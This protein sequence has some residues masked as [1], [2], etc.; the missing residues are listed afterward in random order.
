MNWKTNPFLL[1]LILFSVGL[2]AQVNIPARHFGISFGNSQRFTGIRLNPVDKNIIRIN[3]INV[4]VWPPNEGLDMTGE[5]NGLAIGLPVAAGSARQ[6]GISIG[7]GAVGAAETIRGINLGGLGVGA[8]VDV[9]GLNIGGLGVGAGG[10]VGGINIGGL[11]LGAGERVTGVNIGGLGLGAGESVKGVSIGGL[12]IGAGNQVIGVNIAGL[13]IGAGT[14]LIGLNLAGLGMGSGVVMRGINIAGLGIGAP[15]IKGITVAL[16]VRSE[17]I[18]GLTVAPVY[19]RVKPFDPGL[20]GEMRG[21]AVSAFN[22]V[23]AS[24]RGL[25][26]GILNIADELRGFQIGL[27]NIARSN[28]KG[29]R[30]LPIF[31][32]PFPD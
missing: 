28:R 9:Y 10:S 2:G 24:Q 11:G 18:G 3:G 31:N 32:A 15:D 25:T 19:H 26:I 1:F 23:Q 16:T 8:G 20:V 5:V 30:V 14:E 27:L 6:N 7:I 29:L 4:T 22:N 12:G 17:Y 21:V 13:A